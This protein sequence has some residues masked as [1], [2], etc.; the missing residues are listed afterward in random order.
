MLVL[1]T[2]LGYKDAFM[3]DS[4][5]KSKPSIRTTREM[6]ML[7][8]L[9]RGATCGSATGGSI[10]GAFSVTVSAF[11][12]LGA[13]TVKLGV[14]SSSVAASDGSVSICALE[15]SAPWSASFRTTCLEIS[16]VLDAAR[17]GLRLRLAL[18]CTMPC[19][20]FVRRF[21]GEAV[22]LRC[23]GEFVGLGLRG[24]RDGRGLVLGIGARRMATTNV[25]AKAEMQEDRC[26]KWR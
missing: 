3:S 21:G 16:G 10:A 18:A 14:S 1:G 13:F 11:A 12:A 7:L 8:T 9:M 2:E 6:A 26:L 24:E 5:A 23:L 25:R 19:G 15:R 17:K 20:E 4:A 22:F